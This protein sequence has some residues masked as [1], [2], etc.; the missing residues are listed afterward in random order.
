[1]YHIYPFNKKLTTNYLL[2]RFLMN[3]LK[4]IYIFV[5]KWNRVFSITIWWK[6]VY[7][8]IKQFVVKCFWNTH[9]FL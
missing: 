9:V 7:N 5:L 4:N 2:G 8:S 6:F 1:M 3:T